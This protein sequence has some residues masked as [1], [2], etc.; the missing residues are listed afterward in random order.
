MSVKR[1]LLL[2]LPICLVLYAL[3]LAL[4]SAQMQSGGLSGAVTNYANGQPI[5]S[6]IVRVAD[7]SAVT[8]AEGRYTLLLP[9]GIYDVNVEA[10]GYIDMTRTGWRVA[11][12]KITVLDLEM[13][14]TEPSP[15]EVQAIEKRFEQPVQEGPKDAADLERGYGI[16]TAVSVPATIRVLMPDGSVV[17]MEMDEY[18]KGV[19]PH[20]VPPSWPIE[21][22]RAQAVAARSYAATRRAHADVG[23]DVC[24]TVHCQVWDAM[25][26]ATTDQ[27]VNDTHGIVGTYNSAII[28]A[29]F[30]AHCDGHTRNSEDVWGG[31]LPYCRSV[32]CPCG[33]TTRYGHGVG[34]CQQ[35]ARALA[36]QGVGYAD[37][38]RHYYTGILVEAPTTGQATAVSAQPAAGD[39]NTLFSFEAIYSG[40]ASVFPAVANVVIDGRSYSLARVPGGTTSKTYRYKTRLSAGS[41]LYHVYF[42][43]GY[44]N[45]SRLPV[46]GENAGP[47]VSAADPLTPTPAPAP[48]AEGVLA[49]SIIH[50]TANDWSAGS[51][52][53]TRVTAMGDG[54]LALE[55]DRT[56]GVYT[57][58]ALPAPVPFVGLALTWYAEIPTGA[59]LAL[60][61]RIS[62]DGVVWSDWKSLPPA[63]DD[64]GRHHL[65]TS[66]ILFGQ[67]SWVQYR[68]RFQTTS[69]S[70]TLHNVRLV[71]I[72]SRS[73]PTASELAA[74]RQIAAGR[75][76]VNARS[77]WGADESLMTCAPAYRDPLA[78]IVHHTVTEDGGVDP[79]AIVRAIYYYHA[80]VREWGDIGYNYLVDHLGNVYEG[81]AGGP[82]VVGGHALR[83][84]WGSIGVAL[85]G[86][87]Q[88]NAVPIAMQDS[89]AEFLAW[90]CTDHYIHPTEERYFID[91]NLPT[92]MGHR[93]CAATACP[94]DQAY[95]LLP[96]LRAQVLADMAHVPPRLN[97]IA[98][99]AGQLVRAVATCSLDTS[100]V[101]ERVEYYVDDALRAIATVSPFTWK[102]NTLD[103]S[104][105]AHVLR[106][107]AYNASG[108][109]DDQVNV[110]VDNVPPSGIASAPAWSNS[111]NISLTLQ[112][113]D[114]TLVQFSNGWIWEGEDLYHQPNTGQAVQ[115]ADALNGQA[116]QGRVGSDAAGAW[117]GPYTCE[118]PVGRDY[119]VYFRLKA[120]D[121]QGGNELATLDIC[122][123][124]GLRIYDAAPIVGADFGRVSTY[125][126]FRLE[127]P[128]QDA[129]PTCDDPDTSD[130]V[131]FR[132]TFRAQGDLY[133]DRVTVFSA[134]QAFA[135]SLS[136][137]I[138]SI[139]GAQD[140]V[141][142]FVDAAGNTLDRAVTVGLDTIAPQWIEFSGRTAWVQDIAS[143][144]DTTT[145]AW[146]ISTDG[147]MTWSDWNM[148]GLEQPAGTT[149]PVALTAP[150]QPGT[151]LR[152]RIRDVAGT[153]SESAPQPLQVTPTPTNSVTPTLTMTPTLTPVVSVTCT[154]TREG[155]IAPS[156][157]WLHLPLIQK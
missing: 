39:T 1:L 129:S 107:V 116:W 146:A 140:I 48:A 58:A 130:G 137:N 96:I 101:V 127:L 31:Y 3:P 109:N 46:S 131:E 141:V 132:T 30:F 67:A 70:P 152:C 29:F 6:A 104:A 79:A 63:E 56:G 62:A 102:W 8:D 65:Y 133:L 18:L 64:P 22:L 77:G 95:A 49:D 78:I 84:N 82:G 108:Q 16:T 45:I 54:A 74:S 153:L 21:A 5:V 33:Y 26:Y 2:A 55:T 53:G 10:A 50:S 147:G 117:Y 128:Y 151:H 80:V 88:N 120:I 139:E 86:D 11:D 60:E 138:R 9:D 27:A 119:Q 12:Q 17:T 136:W 105:G 4:P 71:C 123:N 150:E 135:P 24:T 100:A 34:M 15:K 41:H 75:P 59:S 125:E 156:R 85:I 40:N 25:H 89:L 42:D 91:Q 103:E 7:A 68:A 47:Q 44:G 126:E 106:A 124:Q 13:F 144:L 143:G 35:G 28:S 66:D 154:P 110:T 69:T 114:A 36:L 148:L 87:Y 51:H 20:E 142:R 43:D 90:Q 83:Y 121:N 149:T 52:N 112:S 72:D 19:V 99:T 32:S 113:A 134:P 111:T 37:I 73:G 93:D 94:G 92:I 61:A 23:A 157:E 155:T 76:I 14:P 81:R 145:A 57:S 38:L 98:P 118:L 97:L 115:D 122:D